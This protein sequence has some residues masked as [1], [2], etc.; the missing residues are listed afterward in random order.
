MPRDRK[1]Y[2]NDLEGMSIRHKMDCKLESHDDRADQ[3]SSQSDKSRRKAE[4][5]T[6]DVVPEPYARLPGV[7]VDGGGFPG[8][9][10]PRAKAEALLA[11]AVRRLHA[12][13]EV[14]A[15]FSREALAAV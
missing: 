12:S 7:P 15:D 11:D 5:T 6:S 8:V 4:G 9:A 2:N 14:A 3:I 1:K 13:G 10:L